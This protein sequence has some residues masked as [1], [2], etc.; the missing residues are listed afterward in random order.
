MKIVISYLFFLCLNVSYAGACSC[1]NEKSLRDEFNA[2]SIVVV[3][4]VINISKSLEY[5]GFKEVR[6]RLVDKFK[7]LPKVVSSTVVFT[8][9]NE[10]DCGVDFRIGAD[11]LIFGEG[12]P[13]KFIISLCSKTRL[14][15]VALDDYRIL[16]KNLSDPSILAP[17]KLD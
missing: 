8:R 11:Y 4:T 13:V 10:T 12:I 3:G 9:E 5:P 2:S 16:R 1:D 15:D 14:L 6:L 7:G 17:I